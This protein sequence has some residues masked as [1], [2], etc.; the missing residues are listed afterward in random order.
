MSRTELKSPS[1]ITEAEAVQLCQGILEVMKRLELLL[2]EET[3]RV[4]SHAYDA[5][6]ELHN[7]KARLSKAYM[8]FMSALRSQLPFVS[9]V[10]PDM[11]D[12]IR[13]R[14]DTL[15]IIIRDNLT[16]IGA[17]KAVSENLLHTIA[18]EVQKKRQPVT[19]YTAS[20][21]TYQ[22]TRINPAIAVNE[23]F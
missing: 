6:P 7:D 5:L 22:T 16:A 3:D 4:R 9:E 23:R 10:A 1:A 18:E 17:A 19:A 11:V 21:A 15:Q 12:R 13:G 20:G 2:A 8:E 14:H